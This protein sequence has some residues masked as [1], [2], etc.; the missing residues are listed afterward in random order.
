MKAAV[1]QMFHFRPNKNTIRSRI[2]SNANDFDVI[3]FGVIT[4]CMREVRVAHRWH[5]VFSDFCQ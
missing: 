2:H 5:S 3:S 4:M 1:I